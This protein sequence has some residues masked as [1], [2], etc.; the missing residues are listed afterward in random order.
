[1]AN[2]ATTPVK[3]AKNGGGIDTAPKAVPSQNAQLNYD[4]QVART[5]AALEAE[6]KVNFMI[7]LA[8]GEKLGAYEVVAINGYWYTIKKNCMVMIPVTVRNILSAKYQIEAELG[9][10]H[11]YDA[12]EE[13]AKALK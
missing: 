11:R 10:E 9:A 2:K 1:M 4:E 3:N 12:T 6:E 7:P 8:A 5:K 13:R